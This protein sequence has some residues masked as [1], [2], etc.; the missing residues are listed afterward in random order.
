MKQRKE[1]MA[2]FFKKKMAEPAVVSILRQPGYLLERPVAFRALL[3]K[4]LAFR[5]FS[6]LIKSL[7]EGVPTPWRL[8]NGIF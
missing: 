3:T 1:H 8:H 6:P 7:H 5:G 4:G 2:I